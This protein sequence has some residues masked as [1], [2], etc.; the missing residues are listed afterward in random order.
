MFET[1]AMSGCKDIYQKAVRNRA[2]KAVL[3]TT[4]TGVEAY[5]GFWGT[6]YAILSIA[7]GE[8]W[9]GLLTTVGLME[10]DAS[11]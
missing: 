8:L 5:V 6:Q 7:D 1:P 3:S 4:A 2:T 10:A 9:S 11:N